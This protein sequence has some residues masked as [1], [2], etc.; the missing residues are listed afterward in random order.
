MKRIFFSFFTV[1]LVLALAFAA[2][3]CGEN[4]LRI[5]PAGMLIMPEEPESPAYEYEDDLDA[6]AGPIHVPAAAP[7]AD[8]G[9]L[10][11]HMRPPMTLNPL[12]NEDVTVARILRLIFEPLAVLDDELRTTGHLAELDFASDF[13]GVTVRIR[14]DA[15]WSDG[16]PVT[17]DDLVFSVETLR[18]A[19]ARAIYRGNVQNIESIRVVDAK[20]A[21]IT[22]AQASVTAGY[23]LNFPIIPEHLYRGE[24]N[25]GSPRNM[26]PVGNGPFV[27]YELVPIRNI[28]LRRSPHSFQ[29][30]AQIEEIEVIFLP[31]AETDL[32]AFDR[33][34]I[35]A[36]RLPLTEWA[37][38][39]SP[40][41]PR[42]EIFPAMYFE[43]I[44]FNFR[45]PIFRDIHVRQGIAHAF[46]IK[47]AVT[48]VY[49][50][51]A[52]TSVTPIHPYSWAADNI[53]PP[54]F[55]PARASALLGTIRLDEPLI[56]LA[57]AE[58][59]QRVS[60]AQ[61][62]ANALDAAGLPSR[63]EI[64]PD[65]EYFWR[66][67][68]HDFDLFIGGVN[69]PF[70]PDMQFLFQSGGLF[71]YDNLL[72][73]FFSAMMIASTEGAY[74]QAVSQFQHA[75]AERLPVIGLAFRHSA[76]LT[77]SRIARGTNPAPDNIFARIS[78]W[79]IE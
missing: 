25:P 8:D 78:E 5:D 67:D 58:N 32:Y 62:L 2:T 9:I 66:L 73:G 68:S 18:N 33:G 50:A 14:D 46:N 75:F 38:F 17:A 34:R 35:D 70:A 20:T 60:I 40:R 28:T 61:R 31:D 39:H 7:A 11:L 48:A 15:I 57:N 49:M 63:A 10:R 71:Q 27:F 3:A 69:L 16:K 79:V 19:P 36:I 55:D 30:R 45:R 12:L 56:I 1:L 4:S 42:Y 44:G 47:E 21:Q 54:T 53:A 24:T 77:N 13:S 51:H 52:V 59:P 74:L 64:L 29:G 72:D 22:F 37:R 41:T 76:V 65:H 23:A 6:E 26:S 43:F